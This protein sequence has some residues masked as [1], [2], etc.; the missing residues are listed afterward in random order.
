MLLDLTLIGNYMIFVAYYLV[1]NL[2]ILIGQLA[3]LGVSF[4]FYSAETSLCKTDNH[5]YFI[6]DLECL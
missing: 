2:N 6:E 5:I 3:K 1:E 4:H